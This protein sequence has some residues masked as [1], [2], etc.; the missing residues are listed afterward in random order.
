MS[1]F[2]RCGVFC[3]FFQSCW[4]RSQLSP[5]LYFGSPQVTVTVFDPDL[6]FKCESLRRTRSSESNVLSRPFTAHLDARGAPLTD[7]H[8]K[9]SES[10]LDKSSCSPVVSW[11][12][13]S[14]FCAYPSPNIPDVFLNLIMFVFVSKQCQYCP[15]LNHVIC[16]EASPNV[17]DLFPIPNR[18]LFWPEPNQT[19]V[20]F[21]S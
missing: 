6:S 8:I 20:I 12:Y 9:S 2:S 1:F 4:Y 11:P 5:L 17:P 3:F 19:S 16:I 18:V 7:A 10:F 21:S 15:E 13:P 14:R